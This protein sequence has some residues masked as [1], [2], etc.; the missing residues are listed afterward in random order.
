MKKEVIGDAT[1]Y[2]GDCRD[3]LP[4]LGLVD[5]VVT[6]PP[7]GINADVIQSK[8]SGK[9]HGSGVA[10]VKSYCGPNNWDNKKPE[11]ELINEIILKGKYSIIFGGN[12]FQLPVS[13]G[14]LVW[15]KQ[16]DAMHYADCELAWTNIKIPIRKINWMWN[17]MIRRENEKRFHPTQKPLGV[18]QWCINHLPESK[19][20]LDPFMGSGTTGVACMNIDRHFIGIEKE[21]E[22]FEIACKRISDAEKQGDLFINNPGT[23]KNIQMTFETNDASE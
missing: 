12:Y 4:D 14:W 18:M 17:G 22:Y 16:N 13:G 8:R 10:L 20:I 5:A 7:Y 6:D 1:L 21:P 19:T 15:D 23:P 9:K 11:D 3:I 2:Q